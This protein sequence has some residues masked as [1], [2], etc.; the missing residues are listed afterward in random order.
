MTLCGD[1]KCSSTLKAALYRDMAT[2]LAT[3]LDATRHADA[4]ADFVSALKLDPSVK[5]ALRGIPALDIPVVNAYSQAHTQ[6]AIA[7]LRP[8]SRRAGTSFNRSSVAVANRNAIG[9]ACAATSRSRNRS[10]LDGMV[11]ACYAAVMQSLRA[12]V[13]NGRLV[14]DEPTDFR[15]EQRS[16]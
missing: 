15:R 5:P 4:F 2:M 13:H 3:L 16:S 12:H 8:A 14:L 11:V 1:S 9:V 10:I 7:G 6:V